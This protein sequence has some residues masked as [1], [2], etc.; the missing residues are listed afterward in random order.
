M[1][2]PFFLEK[3]L[4]ISITDLMAQSIFF[5]NRFINYHFSIASQ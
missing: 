3:L 1:F 2:L 4:V 5:N